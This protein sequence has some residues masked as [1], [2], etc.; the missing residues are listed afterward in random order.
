MN[1][2]DLKPDID[3]GKIGSKK[4]AKA[5]INKLSKAI[6]YHN[7]RYYVLDS[8]VID[9]SEYD[10][11]LLN[12]IALEEKFPE[13][14]SSDSPTQK[15]GGEPIAELRSIRHSI[16]M[17]SLQT[18]YEESVVRKFDARCKSDL[19]ADVV[20][21]SAEPKFDGLAVELI[22][23]NGSLAIASTRGDGQ[24]GE[25]V[26]TNVKTIRELP[27]VLLKA[28]SIPSRLTVRGEVYIGLEDFEKLNIQRE[29]AG[30]Q[31]FANPR[32]AAAG[33]LR[34]L[35]SKITA[36]RPLRIY[37][38]DV[39]ESEG[40][41]FDTQWD[42]LESLPEWGLPTQLELSRI[43]H[44]L[45]EL[46]EY[47]REL[48]ERRDDLPFEIDGVVF[49]VNAK[50]GQQKMGFRAR[51]P[52]WAIAYKFKPRA[53]TTKLLDITVQ[54]GRTGRLTPVAELE[55]VKIGGVTVSRASLHNQS[56][57]ERKDIRIGDTVMVVRA[58]DVI[59][60]VERPV[61]DSRDGSE[62]AFVMPEECPICNSPTH[63]SIDRK[64]AQCTNISCPA[65]I[66]RSIRHF[67][68]R[69]GMDIEGLGSK[70]VDQL[71]DAGIVTSLLSLYTLNV[72]ALQSLE[73]F[74]ERLA[75]KLLDQIEATKA[76]PPNRF[77]FSLG[78]PNVGEQ[79][80]KILANNFETVTDL[81]SATEGDLLGLET[82]GPEIAR[83]IVDFFQHEDT[84]SMVEG[85]IEVG[86][87][88]KTVLEEAAQVLAGSTF[89]F[90]G[91]LEKIN[92]RDAKELVERLGGK[93]SS[94]VS[95][96]TTHLVAGPGAGSKLKKAQELEIE[97]LSEAEF[98][99]LVG[100]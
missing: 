8:P 25:D 16:P 58:G 92:R 2:D 98:A 7:H 53:A 94:S 36:T 21:Y 46:L 85:L 20:E 96:N 64:L 81:M 32:N 3:I 49:K 86:L 26:T 68:S 56:E 63:M 99:K 89:V 88:K 66:R 37:I 1:D 57:I 5:A 50:S 82:I 18:V 10:S 31:P 72:E 67:A 90:T 17:L 9:D 43:C 24:T 48:D 55:P 47:H 69:S 39:T 73:R 87:G 79:T 51:D 61:V 15:V 14:R 34:Q 60:Q 65:Q 70:R 28:S 93:T 78:I 22:Y 71:V 80:A 23:E 42:A 91:T 11:L 12:L 75:E 33:S 6:R 100:M 38:Y 84:R 29:E 54:V 74:G 35:D 59:P 40:R 83:S 13:L 41:P 62:R 52:R 97:I 95:K 77:I 27:L 76:L 19:G 44:G 4:K 45:D 30:E